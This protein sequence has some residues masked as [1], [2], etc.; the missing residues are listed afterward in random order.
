MLIADRLERLPFSRFHYQLLLLGGAGYCFD[1][2]DGAILSFVMPAL[3]HAW[4]LSTV[5]LG[6]LGSASFLGYFFGALTAGVVADRTGRRTVMMSALACYCIAS[7]ISA[8]CITWHQFILCRVIAGFGTGAESAIIAPYLSEFIP[9]RYRG[10]FTGSLAGFFSFGFVAAALLGYYLIPTSPNG[11]RWALALTSCPVIMLLWWRRVL[12][13]SPRWLQTIGRPL[14]AHNLLC[15]IEYR[16]NIV[17]T[18]FL[19]E[20]SALQKTTLS[21]TKQL[22]ELW[23]KKLRKI[24]IMIWLVWL[25]ITFSYYAF[26]SWIPTLLIAQGFT[27]THSFSFSL[28]IFTAQIP[29]YFTAVVLNEKIGRKA[30]ITVYL[31]AGFISAFAMACSETPTTI[32]ITGLLLSFFMNGTYAGVYAYTPEVFPTFLRATGMGAASA[33]GRIGAIAAPLIIGALYPHTGFMG[34]FALC[35]VTLLVG[36]TAILFLGPSTTNR[37]LEDISS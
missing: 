27:L 16:L 26:F 34:V 20:D 31:L 37:S 22:A 17:P 23:G 33:I 14:E 4:N 11:W 25:S 32:L 28:A 19:A 1:G 12:P 3:Q 2:L 15:E 5:Q 6:M 30:T 7:L 29:G 36:A 13:E 35:S 8:F 18:E 24:T 9:R 21:I 10:M